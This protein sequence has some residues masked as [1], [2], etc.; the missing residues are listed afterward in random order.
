MVGHRKRKP[1]PLS[2]RKAKINATKKIRAA[3][4]Q[5]DGR[6]PAIPERGDHQYLYDSSASDEETQ[7][8][9]TSEPE[10]ETISE[11]ETE[12]SLEF[13]ENQAESEERAEEDMVEQP[14]HAPFYPTPQ[15][16]H[17]S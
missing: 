12:A 17:R 3:R 10:T 6:E 7:I 4:K 2:P 1:P 15:R 5:P 16:R 9:I 11:S 13:D 14:F 8:E